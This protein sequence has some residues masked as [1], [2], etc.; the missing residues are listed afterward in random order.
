MIAQAAMLQLKVEQTTQDVI[1]GL[2]TDS[3]A[4]IR[5][6]STSRRALAA[7][8]AKASAKPAAGETLAEYV[9]RKA[10]ESEA[11]VDNDDE[12]FD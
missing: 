9:A 4:L 2:P 5:L 12:D 6:A 3:D 1:R 11:L 10:A 8:S 7:V